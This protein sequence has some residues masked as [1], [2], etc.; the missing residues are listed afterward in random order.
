MIT[1][2]RIHDCKQLSHTGSNRYL[3]QLTLLRQALEHG[4]DDIWLLNIFDD[5]LS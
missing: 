3:E 4:T 5:T 1:D 2:H